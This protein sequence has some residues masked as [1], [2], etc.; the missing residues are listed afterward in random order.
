MLY[1]RFFILLGLVIGSTATIQAQTT[2]PSC[3]PDVDGEPAKVKSSLLELKF[4][5][6]DLILISV[7]VPD[8]FDMQNI[9]GRRG[10]PSTRWR[11]REEDISLEVILSSHAPNEGGYAQTRPTF[12]KRKDFPD[13]VFTT[14]WSFENDLKELRYEFGAKYFISDDVDG[15]AAT[16]FINSRT[17]EDRELAEAIINSFKLLK[18][19]QN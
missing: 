16:I 11:H 14:I 4:K 18:K 2:D 7:C 8:R 13:G 10:F 1:L 6:V 5:R 17:P 19:P 15:Y 9:V 3:F 12:K